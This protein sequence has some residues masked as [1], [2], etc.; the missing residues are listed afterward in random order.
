MNGKRKR[1][2]ADGIGLGW[3]GNRVGLG[4]IGWSRSALFCQ[5]DPLFL[6]WLRFTVECFFWCWTTVERFPPKRSN[7]WFKLCLTI[8]SGV[9]IENLA[10]FVMLK[11]LQQMHSAHAGKAWGARWENTSSS[12]LHECTSPPPCVL[13]NKWTFSPC[14]N[15][16]LCNVQILLWV[17]GFFF[18]PWRL[19][20][21]EVP[22]TRP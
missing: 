13:W 4:R 11:R 8:I 10:T 12:T 21:L 6:C 22:Y 9:R 19:W 1:G 7:T 3:I 14:A 17:E 20:S 18:D 15:S 16:T 2:L 5:L